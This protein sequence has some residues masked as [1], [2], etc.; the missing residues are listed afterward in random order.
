MKRIEE[1]NKHEKENERRR[2]RNGKVSKEL[3]SLTRL[4]VVQETKNN[5]SSW[6][7]AL[8]IYKQEE[9]KEM[10]TNAENDMKRMLEE[11]DKKKEDEAV[12]DVA[13]TNDS[14]LCVFDNWNFN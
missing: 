10:I 7:T 4:R 2:N 14:L 6:R 1:K 5:K 9:N 13:L 3:K 12:F 8:E 11:M